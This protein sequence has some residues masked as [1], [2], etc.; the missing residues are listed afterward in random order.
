MM[1]LEP[2]KRITVKGALAHPFFSEFHDNQN[3][4]QDEE[5]EAHA[6]HWNVKQEKIQFLKENIFKNKPFWHVFC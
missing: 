2:S 3:G 1:H 5:M 4:F 6:Y